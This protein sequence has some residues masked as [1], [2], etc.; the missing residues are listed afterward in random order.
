MA[1]PCHALNS[2]VA[3]LEFQLESTP[4]GRVRGC[5]HDRFHLSHV[6]TFCRRPGAQ[7]LGVSKFCEGRPSTG[8]TT[9]RGLATHKANLLF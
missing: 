9:G 4:F 5:I 6:D 2:F 3:S 1:T 7:K 8:L